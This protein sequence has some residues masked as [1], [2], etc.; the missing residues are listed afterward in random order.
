MDFTLKIYQKLLESLQNSGYSFFTFEQYCLREADGKF[1]ILRHDVDLRAAHSLATARVEAELGIKA[2]YYFRVVRQSNKPEIIK[3]IAALGHEIGYHYEDMSLVKGNSSIAVDHFS[4]K[5]AYFRRFY[6]VKTVCMHG[7]PT[8]K[9]DNRSLWKYYDYR[10][11]GLIG[12]PYFDIDFTKVFYLTDTGRCWDGDKFSV[13]D[14]VDAHFNVSYHSTN[15]IIHAANLKTL[16]VQLMITTHPQR[17]T[18]NVIEWFVE[19]FM[20]N[21]KNTIKRLIVK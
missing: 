19:L 8:S 7:S 10:D 12:E 21:A 14:K 16:P 2:S 18:D 17:W 9:I 11:F 3:A 6:P 5:L 13:R 4:A 15:E 1:V 20:Q